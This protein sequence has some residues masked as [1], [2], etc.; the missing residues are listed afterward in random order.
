MASCKPTN[1]P[2]GIDVGAC[3]SAATGAIITLPSGIVETD[4]AYQVLPADDIISCLGTFT[5]TLPPILTAIKPVTITSV[6]GVI[7]LSGDATIQSPTSVT[8]GSS[9]TVYPARGQWFQL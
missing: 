9:V 1:Y 8:T 4:I 7:T 3:L 6:T 5:V 2:N